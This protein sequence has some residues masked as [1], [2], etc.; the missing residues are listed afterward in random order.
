MVNYSYLTD[1]ICTRLY[2]INYFYPELKKK[3]I[4]TKDETSNAAYTLG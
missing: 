1:I 3:S 4:S 2:G